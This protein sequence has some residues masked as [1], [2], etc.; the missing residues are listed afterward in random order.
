MIGA[1]ARGVVH[2][3]LKVGAGGEQPAS[4][5]EPVAP[6]VRGGKQEDGP[7]GKPSG[8]S[9]DVQTAPPSENPLRSEP[10]SQEGAPRILSKAAQDPEAVQV[11]RAV[12][13]RR[14]IRVLNEPFEH[15]ALSLLCLLYTSPSPRDATLSRMPSSA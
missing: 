9:S 13:Q 10:A 7:K 6:I 12:S 11:E 3:E 1:A 14:K 4:V 2:A 5:V 8:S 15:P